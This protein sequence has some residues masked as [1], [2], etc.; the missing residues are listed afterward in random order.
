MDV[1]R[2]P[3]VNPEFRAT[4]DSIGVRSPVTPGVC[5]VAASI[6]LFVLDLELGVCEGVNGVFLG[7][8]SV[9]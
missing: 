1:G 9:P 8:C 3:L 2:L 4:G 7:T 5:G 6:L